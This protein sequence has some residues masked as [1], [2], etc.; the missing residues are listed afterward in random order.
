MK[1]EDG[2]DG[3]NARMMGSDVVT[4]NGGSGDRQVGCSDCGECRVILARCCVCCNDECKEGAKIDKKK[5]L[6]QKSNS[7]TPGA[8]IHG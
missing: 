5:Q 7:Q 8:M 6:R 3:G 4:G 2:H 1:C